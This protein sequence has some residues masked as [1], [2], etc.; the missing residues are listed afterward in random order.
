MFFFVFFCTLCDVPPL[1]PV[2]SAGL[3]FEREREGGGEREREREKEG[4]INRR[5]RRVMIMMPFFFLFLQKQQIAYRHM[6][7]GYRVPD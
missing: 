6:P 4:S 7:I 5:L 1:V 3:A 2:S